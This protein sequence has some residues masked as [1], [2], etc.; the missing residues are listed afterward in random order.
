MLAGVSLSKGKQV[1]DPDSIVTY[2]VLKILA[3]CHL[4]TASLVNRRLHGRGPSLSLLSLISL[5]NFALWS[6]CSINT[7]RLF[8]SLRKGLSVRIA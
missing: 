8:P 1:G 3:V 5:R 4:K 6:K 2:H 7:Y